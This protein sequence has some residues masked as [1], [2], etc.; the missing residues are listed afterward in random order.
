MASEVELYPAG[1]EGLDEQ[2]FDP[3]ELDVETEAEEA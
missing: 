1:S 2:V 3:E